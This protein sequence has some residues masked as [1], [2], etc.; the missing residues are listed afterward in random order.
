MPSTRYNRE[1]ISL[2]DP[3]VLWNSRAGVRAHTRNGSLRIWFDGQPLIDRK[4]T[5]DEIRTHTLG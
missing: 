4:S 1:T 2:V 5:G 3:T